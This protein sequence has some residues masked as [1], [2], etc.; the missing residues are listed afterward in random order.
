MAPNVVSN[1]A[2]L[3][4]AQPGEPT[5]SAPVGRTASQLET[6]DGDLMLGAEAIARFLGLQKRRVYRIFESKELPLF[7]LR[8]QI[9]G[10]RS[11]LH[12]AIA[13]LENVT[14]NEAA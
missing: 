5:A 13:R 2:E 8:G 9:A 11:T 4:M 10:R 6:L 1:I 7:K 3:H 14:N 12:K